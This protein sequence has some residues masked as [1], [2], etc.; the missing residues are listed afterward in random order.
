MNEREKKRKERESKCQQRMKRDISF[1]KRN[2][3]M[4][5]YKKEET[6]ISVH[7]RERERR[8]R[9]R[10]KCGGVVRWRLE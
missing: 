8:Q 9:K 2:E 4:E 3:V 1:D 10:S 5:K 7:R 6:L